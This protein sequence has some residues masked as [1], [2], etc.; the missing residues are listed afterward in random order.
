MKTLTVE[1]TIDAPIEQVFAWLETSTNYTRT[2]WAVRCR[3]AKAGA[4]APYGTGAIRIHTWIIG[5]FH[6]VITAYEAP[7]SFDYLVDRSFPPIRHDGGRVE[8]TEVTGGTR[9]VWS[10]TGE[11]RVP[12]I[13]AFLSRVVANPLLSRVFGS[14][15]RAA[16][17]ALTGE[18]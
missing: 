11:P 13:G 8:L 15:L 5:W 16:D 1:R 17:K 3:L 18:Q 2:P 10:T 12:L 4:E 9:V 14:I 7:R 6:E